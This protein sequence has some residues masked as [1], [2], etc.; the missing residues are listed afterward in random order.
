MIGRLKTA[1][2]IVAEQDEELAKRR[3]KE[4]NL[5]VLKSIGM[6]ALGMGTGTVAGYLA[7][8]GVDKLMRRGGGAGISPQSAARWI[9]PLAVGGMGMAMGSWRAH[10]DAMMRQAA[11]EQQRASQTK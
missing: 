11:E 10:Q 3:L 8:K 6:G 4:R 5:E 7:T 1:A 9:A 2:E